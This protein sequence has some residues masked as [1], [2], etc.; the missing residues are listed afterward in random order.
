MAERAAVDGRRR[1][2]GTRSTSFTGDWV[3]RGRGREKAN[4]SVRDAAVS[5]ANAKER[6]AELVVLNLF[7]HDH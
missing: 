4:R 1:R 2:D 3:R 7:K 5:D 6:L